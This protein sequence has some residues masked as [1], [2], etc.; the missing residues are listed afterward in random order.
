[1]ER[2]NSDMERRCRRLKNGRPGEGPVVYWVSR[3]QRA[4][5]NWALLWAQQEAIIQQKGLLVVFCL[6]P[7]YLGA[8]S[9]HY[10]FMLNGMAVMREK[11]AE[12][13][14]PF[15][16]LEESPHEILPRF[17]RQIDA[18]VLVT[19]FDPLRIKRQWK[20]QLLKDVVA[21]VYEVDAH[22]VIPA[23][24]VSDK[25]EYAAYTLRPK[26]QRLLDDYLTELPELRVHP[27]GLGYSGDFSQL[28]CRTE[29]GI[30]QQKVL[31]LIAGEVAGLDA[32]QLFVNS[33]LAEYA[34]NRNNPC[35]DGQSGLSPYLHFGHLSP[36]RLALLASRSELSGEKIEPFL[37][38][39]IVR[40]EL[41][42]NFCLYEPQ[43][44]A[45]AG[46]PEW[47]QKTLNEHRN[48]PREYVYSLQDLEAGE[49][50]EQ[51]WNAC[52]IDLV[53][54]GKLHGYLRMYWAKKIL[55]WT[56]DPETAMEYAITLNDRYSLDGRDPNGYTGIA[57]SI[58]GVHDR[59]WRERPVFGK[60][61]YMNEAG[62]RRK[63]DV[64][65]YIASVLSK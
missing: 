34:E 19:D 3:D 9:V 55:E 10:A 39:L 45:F 54:H 17:L 6:I 13:Q 43:Y 57:W 56:S 2:R 60:I 35:I 46:F 44:D 61:R 63:F 12:L 8:T 27:F 53:R 32:A 25:K 24:L 16:L 18:H 62:C 42:D 58:G 48:D 52:Q 40:R 22:N 29:L 51:L 28:P 4:T 47:A 50:H 31:D 5:D 11:L 59:A 49:T 64:P 21:P 23:W 65:G 30:T 33:R 1:M 14:I 41:S 37:E 38:E 26:I 7:E 36:Q 20:Q 15:V